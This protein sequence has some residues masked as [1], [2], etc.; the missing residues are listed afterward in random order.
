MRAADI[1]KNSADNFQLCKNEFEEF[2]YTLDKKHLEKALLLKKELTGDENV[3]QA[4]LVKTAQVFGLKNFEQGFQFP[5][6]AH[7]QEAEDILQQ[8][9]IV[10]K[11]LNR[12]LQSGVDP[13]KKIVSSYVA[14]GEKAQK[15]LQ[16]K[17]GDMWTKPSADILAGKSN[18]IQTDAMQTDDFDEIIEI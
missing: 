3:D 8:F 18:L 16:A 11:D 12:E 4:S 1:K 10:E 2:S 14:T 6:V 15:A 7:N 5:G 17:Y 9:E 13:G